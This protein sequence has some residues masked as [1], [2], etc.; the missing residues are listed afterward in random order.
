MKS[1]ILSSSVTAFIFILFMSLFEKNAFHTIRRLPDS[2][3]IIIIIA[4]FAAYLLSLYWGITGIIKGQRLFNLLGI[5]FSLFGLCIYVLG[6]MVNSGGGK[7]TPNQFD[8][9]ITKIENNQG[10]A[11]EELLQQTNTKPENLQCTNYWGMY[12]NPA[13]FVICIQKGNIISLQIKN[14]P[15]ND[16]KTVTKFP[17]LSWLILE[18]CD[19][20]SIADL[21]LP[22]LDRLS[23][24]GNQLTSLTGFENEPKVSWIDY[25][26]NPIIDS[27][28]ITTHPNKSLYINR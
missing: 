3:L 5:G 7:E 26:N 11:L 17:H 10:I 18:N 28:A 20:K 16:V 19:L 22:E 6:Y 15:V 23:V 8:R 27:S 2:I 14:K 1:L 13:E 25:G 9:D 12:K 4:F 21:K 24:K